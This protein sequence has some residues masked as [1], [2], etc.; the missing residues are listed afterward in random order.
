ML[1]W[2]RVHSCLTVAGGRGRHAWVATD[3]RW[4]PRGQRQDDVFHAGQDN[5]HQC[6]EVVTPVDGRD[7]QRVAAVM[8]PDRGSNVD[9]TRKN[10]VVVTRGSN[11]KVTRWNNVDVTHR[12]ALAYN[13]VIITRRS[14]VVIT[15]RT[16]TNFPCRWN[17]DLTI[18]FVIIMY[19]S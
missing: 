17:I 6:K 5:W 2:R 10:H 18:F 19:P 13:N 8:S 1:Y 9:V 11:V 7:R 12:G 3:G 15:R 4:I 14:N 16:S